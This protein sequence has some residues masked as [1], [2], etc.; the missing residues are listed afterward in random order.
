MWASVLPASIM[1]PHER[2]GVKASCS[3]LIGDA[4]HVGGFP[5]PPTSQP[6]SMSVSFVARGR[7]GADAGCRARRAEVAAE[8]SRTVVDALGRAAVRELAQ[9]L[10]PQSDNAGCE[11]A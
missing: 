6:P 4:W 5:Q 1:Q 2:Q 8:S 7:S 11:Q 3:R 10:V 9:R